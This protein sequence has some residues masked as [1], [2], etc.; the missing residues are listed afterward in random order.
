[1]RWG[2]GGAKRSRE[3]V[4]RPVVICSRPST[5]RIFWTVSTPDSRSVNGVRPGEGAER[6]GVD[7]GEAGVRRAEIAD[8][9]I[10]PV[11]AGAAVLAVL[12]FE[13]AGARPGGAVPARQRAAAVLVEALVGEVGGE[14]VAQAPA[15]SGP[16]ARDLGAGQRLRAE[17]ERP[18]HQHAVRI[19][20][21]AERP[22]VLGRPAEG[23][24]L[25]IVAGD[26]AAQA[27][28]VAVGELRLRAADCRPGR[29]SRPGSS[30]PG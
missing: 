24:E 11:G 6:E 20:L 16:R 17:V 2:E 28:L 23:G 10:D 19:D 30:G 5:K 7:A 15:G 21:A 26:L 14:H 13:L 27:Q 25:D 1:M 22:D 18:R 12:I 3:R 29:W 9:E 8:R 4:K